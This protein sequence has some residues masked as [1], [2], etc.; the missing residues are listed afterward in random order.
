MA[1]S[2]GSTEPPP[3]VVV[4]EGAT[5][6]AVG[7]NHSC[8]V[9]SGHVYCWGAGANGELGN[10]APLPDMCTGYECR[11]TPTEVVGLGFPA[12]RVVANTGTTCASV[13]GR[14]YCWGSNVFGQLGNDACDN[15]SSPV[16]PSNLGS[17]VTDLS[18]GGEQIGAVAGQRGYVWGGACG[19]TNQGSVAVVAQGLERGVTALAVGP[20]HACAVQ[21][22]RVV[23][24]GDNARGQLGD[25]TTEG[26]S[27]PAPVPGIEPA[28]RLVAVGI[29]HSCAVAAGAAYCWGSNDYGQLGDGSTETSATPVAVVG[30]PE[31][32]T[33][34]ALAPYHSCAVAAG[35][36]YCW[37]ANP[38][39]QLGDGSDADSALPVAVVGLPSDVTAIAAGANHSCAVASSAVYCWG[40]NYYGSLGYVP[41]ENAC[42]RGMDCSLVPVLIGLPEGGGSPEGLQARGISASPTLSVPGPS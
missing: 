18:D 8:A 34:L 25:G 26:H 23:C 6:V 28:A 16:Q 10:D 39:G 29:D 15:T 20:H 32:V 40:L 17:G 35:A 3:P 12:T 9:E 11:V 33:A 27:L 24:F 2:S 41:V 38:W 13:S 5:S 31:P 30:L 42:Y 21:N 1:C 4:P 22:G 7:P 37:G 19:S 36:A 14:A